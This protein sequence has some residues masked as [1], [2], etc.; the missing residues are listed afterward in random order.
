MKS[1]KLMCILLVLN[2]L[3]AK[4]YSQ[5]TTIDYEPLALSP[6]TCLLYIPPG[7][8]NPTSIAGFN[9]YG[10]IGGIDYTGDEMVLNGD[11]IGGGC[12]YGIGYTFDPDYRYRIVV[13]AKASATSMVLLA[14]ASKFRSVSPTSCAPGFP[15]IILSSPDVNTSTT[16]ITSTY[17]D[18]TVI[19]NYVPTQSGVAY[20]QMSGYNTVGSIGNVQI[21]KITI[22][23]ACKPAVINS[24]TPL[25]S[26]QVQI[27]FTHPNGGI[28]LSNYTVRMIQYTIVFV[29]GFPIIIPGPVSTFPNVGTTSPVTVTAPAPGNYIVS[30]ESQCTS[31]TTSYSN[32]VAVVVN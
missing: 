5:V 28:G 30:M 10:I 12:G 22:T 19:D 1:L 32:S 16:S 14:V 6:I 15:N 24:V 31:G 20:F 4:G 26:N 7:P 8:T 27:A 3:I 25:G 29:A 23:K 11:N 17:A 2:A 21:Q 13:K 9:H 18:Y